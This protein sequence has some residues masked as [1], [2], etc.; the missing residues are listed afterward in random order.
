MYRK[1][2]TSTSTGLDELR[3][4]EAGGVWGAETTTPCMS[5]YIYV[6]RHSFLTENMIKIPWYANHFFHWR[7]GRLRGLWRGAAPAWEGNARGTAGEALTLQACGSA[8]V[9]R[10]WRP[11]G[12][13]VLALLPAIPAMGSAVGTRPGRHLGDATAPQPPGSTWQPAASGFLEMLSP[14]AF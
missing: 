9:Q 1:S 5:N 7:D 2:L 11:V 3:S 8:A 10:G 4:G 14:L 6:L 12:G 13:V